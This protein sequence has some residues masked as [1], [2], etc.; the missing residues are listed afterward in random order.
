M[1]V[2]VLQL[3]YGESQH[4]KHECAALSQWNRSLLL[5]PGVGRAGL[6]VTFMFSSWETVV[7]IS[8]GSEGSTP[9]ISICCYWIKVIVAWGRCHLSGFF[10][11]CFCLFC[12]VLFAFI[13]WLRMSNIYPHFPSKINKY[14]HTWPR[15]WTVSTKMNFFSIFIRYLAHL[16]F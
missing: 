8:I 15:G 16:H 13:G 10:C 1:S 11:C 4:S 6:Y 2:V 14:S 7:L 3:G 12:F 5:Y 9:Q